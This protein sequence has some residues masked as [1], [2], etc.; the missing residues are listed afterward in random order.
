[1]NRRAVLG[2]TLLPMFASPAA[3]AEE[4]C[5]PIR[6]PPGQYSAVVRGVAHS[7]DSSDSPI[8]CYMLMTGRGQTATLAI[9]SHGPHDDTAFS[10]PGVIDNRDRYS[11]STEAKTYKVLIYR[12]FARESDIPFAM[13]VTVR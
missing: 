6:F 11:F 9:Q 3:H 5:I 4:N 7:S 13:R 2:A 1:V 12:T 10:I 8:T